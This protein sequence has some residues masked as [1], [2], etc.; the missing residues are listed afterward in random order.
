MN[1]LMDAPNHPG[2]WGEL[3]SCG[4]A[5]WLAAGLALPT[6]APPES[7]SL[8]VLT[9]VFGRGLCVA[10]LLMAG[11]LPI[12]GIAS[13][14]W[15]VRLVGTTLAMFTWLLLAG[16]VAWRSGV[17]SPGVGA[18]LVFFSACCVA[19]FRLMR[20]IET[21]RRWKAGTTSDQ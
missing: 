3:L 2:R 21:E 14:D 4:C 12:V 16:V 9:E 10:W 1:R 6:W 19:E 20:H 8:A 5:L 18:Y 11:A 7:P 15:V 13:G 17:L